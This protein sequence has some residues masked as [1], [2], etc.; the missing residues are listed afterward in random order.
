VTTL[1]VPAAAAAATPGTVPGPV[2]ISGEIDGAPFRIVVPAGWNGTLLVYA[3]GYR[4]A[5]DH[6][7]ELDDRSVQLALTP[8][9]TDAL[10][11]QGFALA[12][13]AYRKNGWAVGEALEDVRALA[14]RFRDTVA[15]PAR[16]ILWG[17]SMGT[18]VTLKTAERTNGLFDGYLVA[19]A[20]GAGAPR[21]V[22]DGTV[23]LR[24]AYDVAFGMPATWGTP[25][26]VRDDLDYDSEVRP[27]L[28][29]EASAPGGFARTEFIRLVVGIPGSGVQAPPGFF[30]GELEWPFY[31]ATEA[32]AELDRRAGGPPGQNRDHTYRLTDDEKSY[33]R[34]LGLEPD[35]LLAA[36]NARRTISAAPA[37]RNFVERF[38]DYSGAVK[39]PVVALHTSVDPVTPVSHESA[40]RATVAAAGRD[41]LLVQAYTRGAGHCRFTQEQIQ[42]GITVLDDWLSTGVRPPASAFPESLAFQPG[43]V[44]PPWP[45][46]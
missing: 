45:Q 1:L 39:G 27:K 24:L 8:G 19:C 31:Y 26:D 40:Y 34:S 29:A 14:S 18:V 13:T 2:D 28:L 25:G 3:H 32:A 11:R 10:L 16:T 35:P 36:M 7:G 17:N 6:R 44:P 12:G 23:A 42:V 33:L 41:A 37:P 15:R 46:P 9:S 20:V 5:A 43:F 4:D 38:A 30:P 21:G 22:A